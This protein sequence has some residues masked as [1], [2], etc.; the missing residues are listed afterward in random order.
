MESQQIRARGVTRV[1]Y[2]IDVAKPLRVHHPGLCEG[3][4]WLS[5]AAS[6]YVCRVHRLGVGATLVL[7][8]PEAGTEASAELLQSG[9]RASC[10]VGAVS[11]G[12]RT[13][14]SWVSLYLG[15]PKAPALER[16]VRDTV[17]LGAG[18]LVLL[19][20]EHG[21]VGDGELNE[22]RLREL[23]IDEA[24]QCERSDL[25][26]ISGP[27]PFARAV[28]ELLERQGN[29]ENHLVLDARVPGVPLLDAVSTLVREPREVRGLNLWIGP[30]GGFSPS[31]LERLRTHGARP[32]RLGPLVLKVQSAVSV[33]LGAVL[34]AAEAANGDKWAASEPAD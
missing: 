5:E 22:R 20:T 18:Q 14:S 25:P 13:G 16:V 29:L 11:R 26:R 2:D 33:A 27:V 17:S 10:R 23:A 30:E 34:C 3:E 4:T 6:R 24:R 8:D 9:R 19:T 32:V 7:F 28:D 12:E 1:L 31:E 15:R 21:A